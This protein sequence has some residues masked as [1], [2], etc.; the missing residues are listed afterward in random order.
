MAEASKDHPFPSMA[1]TL[2]SDQRVK[3]EQF[4]TGTWKSKNRQ[5][6]PGKKGLQDPYSGNLEQP[7]QSAVTVVIGGRKDESGR[8]KAGV[9]IRRKNCS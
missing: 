1:G 5:L 7:W 8:Q 3:S 4:E 6:I 9:F 2:A